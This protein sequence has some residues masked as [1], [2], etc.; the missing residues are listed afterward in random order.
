MRYLVGLF[1]LLSSLVLTDCAKYHGTYGSKYYI[2]DARVVHPI[3]VPQGVSSPVGEQYFTVPDKTTGYATPHLS[4]LPPDPILQAYL[5]GH[6]AANKR[7][8]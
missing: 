6:Y 4:L 1:V 7:Q 5:A 3:V 8:P 2:N